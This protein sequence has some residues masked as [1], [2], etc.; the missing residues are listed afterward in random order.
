[1]LDLLIQGAQS[2]DGRLIDVSVAKGTIVTMADAHHETIEARQI[3]DASGL[4]IMPGVVDPHTHLNYPFDEP[5]TSPMQSETA[6]AAAGGV[7]TVGHYPLGVRG[8]LRVH[9]AETKDTIEAAANVDVAL[10]YPILEADQIGQ[11][12][13]L[14]DLGV[15]SFKILRAYRAPDVY[16]FGGVDDAL[17]YRALQEVARM[18]RDGRRALLKVHCENVDIFR[19]YRE[20]MQ[21]RYPDLGRDSPLEEVTWAHCRPDIVESESVASAVYLA[22]TTGCPIMI[23]HL[24][25]GLSLQPIRDAKALGAEIYVETTPLYLETDAYHTGAPSGPFW[26]RVQP[27]V[28]FEADAEALWTAI[29]DGTI[30]L[31]GTDHA[32]SRKEVYEGKSVWDHGASGRSLLGIGLPIMLDAAHRGRLNLPRLAEVLCET[33][34]RMLN[35]EHRK[36]RLAVGFDADFVLCDL[37]EVREVT[38]E[39][40]HS[41]ADHTCFEGRKLRG[42]PVTTFVRGQVIWDQG[43]LV[44]ENAGRYVPGR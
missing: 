42:W 2:L 14:Y 32:A 33:P 12:D 36:G 23:V 28:K 27:S 17:F 8:D 13:E 22:R 11:L 25:S 44:K 40:L 26:T 9:L 35:L 3:I 19:V 18:R 20:Q 38:V 30:D 39:D 41:R 29:D 21:T 37:D 5:P 1:M 34:A 16:D 6:A 15:T 43:R 31:I 24:S 4:M 7:T 10:A